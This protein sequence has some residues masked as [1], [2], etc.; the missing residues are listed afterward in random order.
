M[1]LFQQRTMVDGSMPYTHVAEVQ[2]VSFTG[3][4]MRI[5]LISV[6]PPVELPAYYL[7]DGWSSGDPLVSRELVEAYYH[8]A[9]PRQPFPPDYN[10][11]VDPYPQIL[12]EYVSARYF[13]PGEKVIVIQDGQDF[14][15]VS[16]IFPDQFNTVEGIGAEI[17]HENWLSMMNGAVF[18][19]IGSSLDVAVLLEDDTLYSFSKAH[20]PYTE[21][22]YMNYNLAYTMLRNA[23]FPIFVFPRE[24][25][26][27][28]SNVSWSWAG[29][30]YNYA[31]FDKID[32]SLYQKLYS[33]YERFW[34][35]TVAFPGRTPDIRL[36]VQS[37][38]PPSTDWLDELP[39]LE[40]YVTSSGINLNS[41]FRDFVNNDDHVE[42]VLSI[43]RPWGYV[44][45]NANEWKTSNWVPPILFCPD[46]SL[47]DPPGATDLPKPAISFGFVDYKKVAYTGDRSET[48]NEY[49]FV[50]GK[51]FAELKAE[52][53]GKPLL[54]KNDYNYT[55]SHIVE[56]KDSSYTLHV[57]DTYEDLG[58][59]EVWARTVRM[60][61]P[62]D[63]E[64][65]FSVCTDGTNTLKKKPIISYSDARVTSELP[66]TRAEEISLD[67]EHY[68]NDT[69]MF[70]SS[71]NTNGDR[72]VWNQRLYY[73]YSI[74]LINKL[75]LAH[76]YIYDEPNVI[77]KIE[78]VVIDNGVEHVI[79]TFDRSQD[80]DDLSEQANVPPWLGSTTFPEHGVGG[81][82]GDFPIEQDVTEYLWKVPYFSN[83][84]FPIDSSTTGDCA[85]AGEPS[86]AIG[87]Y[88]PCSEL[89]ED[90]RSILLLNTVHYDDLVSVQG[91][92]QQKQH[93]IVTPR[94]NGWVAFMRCCFSALYGTISYSYESDIIIKKDGIVSDGAYLLGTPDAVL[95]TYEV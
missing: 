61:N 81:D 33:E 87:V 1:S 85:F 84:Y 69:L 60:N 63:V 22:L 55:E 10:P 67:I 18:I 65:L 11:E 5:K 12:T 45:S 75:I 49:R 34:S 79:W 41:S 27:H 92:T 15:V 95:N 82:P 42:L 76:V 29:G 40:F 39:D 59:S 56:V 14:F 21:M 58:G 43:S 50:T 89:D 93:N 13:H 30:A 66:T 44:A 77:Q 54:G 94:R 24:P 51:V 23:R 4:E 80:F 6:S 71:F 19:P 3:P 46:D 57:T 37:A 9:V 31:Y 8:P 90:I 35:P 26:V 47:S 62:G 91:Y 7:P 16:H 78:G 64:Q 70:T 48:T 83:I 88:F 53:I 25:L 52:S 36:E 74:D 2:A 86:G 72:S 73:L 17:E 38:T 20:I 32:D 68:I 28:L